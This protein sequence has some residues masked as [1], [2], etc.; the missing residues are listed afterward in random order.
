MMIRGRSC[1]AAFMA[2]AIL[3]LFSAPAYPSYNTEAGHKYSVASQRLADLR[4]SPKKKKYRSYWIDCIRTFELVEK[5]YPEE[6]ECRGRLF[7]PG[8]L[9]LGA[10]SIQQVF[11]RSGRILRPIRE[12]PVLLSQACKGAGSAL[13]CDR[14]IPRFKKRTSADAAKAYAKLSKPIPTA[15][16]P[17]RRKRGWASPSKRNKSRSRRSER[18][19]CRSSLLRE[20]RNAPAL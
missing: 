18:C 3:L 12:V 15:P 11:P 2:C 4:K 8:G 6:P 5:K 13:P 1:I 17:A 20:S 19:P 9:Y 7:R 14:H 10:L 16:G